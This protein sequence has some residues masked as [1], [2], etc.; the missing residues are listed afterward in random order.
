MYI[1]TGHH[2]KKIHDTIRTRASTIVKTVGQRSIQKIFNATRGVSKEY[3]NSHN[4][5]LLCYKCNSDLIPQEAAIQAAP[6]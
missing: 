6:R 2:L 1:L 4:F 5:L 3:P